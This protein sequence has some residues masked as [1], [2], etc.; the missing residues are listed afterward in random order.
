[1]SFKP[2]TLHLGEQGKVDRGNPTI[3]SDLLSTWPIS[4]TSPAGYS[5]DFTLK[6]SPPTSE[7]GTL[8]RDKVSIPCASITLYV[9]VSKGASD[10]TIS[11]TCPNSSALVVTSAIASQSVAEKA[12]AARVSSAAP[13]TGDGTAGIPVVAVL[14]EHRGVPNLPLSP[15][16]GPR[17]GASF[18]LLSPVQASGMRR[19]E[20][21]AR[22]LDQRSLSFDLTNVG[23]E[24]LRGLELVD[25]NHMG[26]DGLPIDIH[27]C[28][29]T[30]VV[31][32][33]GARMLRTG[34]AGCC[35][36]NFDAARDAINLFSALS[37]LAVPDLATADDD[38]PVPNRLALATAFAEEQ[39]TIVIGPLEDASNASSLECGAPERSFESCIGAAIRKAALA[40]PESPFRRRHIVVVTGGLDAR[41]AETFATELEDV[42]TPAVSNSRGVHIHV[43][44][45]GRAA[46]NHDPRLSQLAKDYDGRYFNT[47]SAPPSPASSSLVMP[48]LSIL[49]ELLPVEI[50][51]TTPQGDV[52]VE[53]DVSHAF[54]A[55]RSS[56]GRGDCAVFE[57]DGVRSRPRHAGRVHD[58]AFS[59]TSV[60]LPGAWNAD[61]CEEA[62]PLFALLESPIDF[63]CD[64]AVDDATFNVKLAASLTFRGIPIDGA[65]VRA[66]M[67]GEGPP[68]GCELTRFA[69]AG[70]IADAVRLRTLDRR[71]LAG[72]TPTSLR[73]ALLDAA[74][75]SENTEFRPD[76]T[77]VTLG[78]RDLDGVYYADPIDVPSGV[79]AFAFRADG[80]TAL[81]S[82]FSRVD[83]VVVLTPAIPSMA[84]SFIWYERKS[85]DSETTT[86]VATFVLKTMVPDD[87][88]QNIGPGL[89]EEFDVVFAPGQNLPLEPI[90]VSDNWDGTYS[91][92]FTTP[93]KE[94]SLLVVAPH[95]ADET[96]SFV[97]HAAPGTTRHVT[98]DLLEVTYG[99]PGDTY[100]A[101]VNGVTLIA[102]NASLPRLVSTQLDFPGLTLGVPLTLP[103][104]VTVFD[105]DVEDGARLMLALG[106]T[107]LD[108]F[109]VFEQPGAAAYQLLPLVTGPTRVVEMTSASGPWRARCRVAVAGLVGSIIPA[110]DEPERPSRTA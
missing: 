35:G 77:L 41:D 2:I 66:T 51:P 97:L 5:G 38:L 28:S 53:N 84:G 32:D 31:L 65:H 25:V 50:V 71:S 88:V 40:F 110:A 3:K 20:L 42:V 79:T 75:A 18:R 101:P 13:P 60:A 57:L 56:G 30:I 108:Y 54:F 59:D 76:S 46:E 83:E 29:D 58:Y 74:E 90:T 47:A 49:Q 103:A 93:G 14:R 39:D 68:L 72:D 89:S 105:G 67:Y 80:V 96:K 1:M 109:Q 55:S 6:R 61:G 23:L 33:R 44:V 106:N 69:Q 94:R 70:G 73:R 9:T 37:A 21:D 11:V 22:V 34:G 99:E 86:W 43:I 98:I 78:H 15:P 107:S 24:D 82:V 16:E 12:S 10:D 62:R 64:A 85:A 36:T 102:P 81:G 48:L 52:V 19:I 7:Q 45:L 17:D 63:H 87:S 104:A 4:R 26:A 95:D 8:T 92:E 91:A 100:P 27:V